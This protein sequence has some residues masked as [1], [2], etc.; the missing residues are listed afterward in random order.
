MIRKQ[1]TQ[2]KEKSIKYMLGCNYH[3][4]ENAHF[5]CFECKSS[6]CSLCIGSHNNHN[7]IDK[8][9]YSMPTEELVNSIVE[10]VYSKISK[11]K[12]EYPQYFNQTTPTSNLLNN[13]ITPLTDY[14][15]SLLH[16]NSLIKSKIAYLENSYNPATQVNKQ[17]KQK[18]DNFINNLNKFKKLCIESLQNQMISSDKSLYI[19]NSNITSE[20]DLILIEEDLFLEIHKTVQQLTKGKSSLL[21]YIDIIYNE[22]IEDIKNLIKSKE[23]IHK[24]LTTIIIQGVS[25]ITNDI[26]NIK[27]LN[28]DKDNKYTASKSLTQFSSQ[29]FQ[30]D[31]NFKAALAHIDKSLII[32]EELD[33]END[34]TKKITYG[35]HKKKKIAD[36][37]SNKDKEQPISKFHQ[38]KSISIKQSA[39]SKQPSKSCTKSFLSARVLPNAA[40]NIK[41][42]GSK[43]KN[44]SFIQSPTELIKS[45]IDSKKIASKIISPLHDN[46]SIPVSTNSSFF[47]S[48]LSVFNLNHISHASQSNQECYKFFKILNNINVNRGKLLK[49]RSNSL[50]ISKQ[51]SSNIKNINEVIKANT[52]LLKR[53]LDKFPA[54][55]AYNTQTKLYENIIIELLDQTKVKKFYEFSIFLNVNNNIYIS[56]G[57]KKNKKLSK[58]FLKYSYIN[59]ELIKLPEMINGKCSHSLIFNDKHQKIYSV[60]GFNSK[61]CEEYS[62][63][64]NKWKE[65]TPLNYIRQVATL[66]FV[67]NKYLIASFGFTS[68]ESYDEIEYFERLNIEDQENMYNIKESKWEM[69]KIDSSGLS[70]YL[71]IFNTGI[72][73]LPE[74]NT[75]LICGGETFQGQETDNVYFLD[76][77]ED[78]MILKPYYS[79]ISTISNT[80]KQYIV[81]LPN[82]TS[83]IDKEFLSIGDGKYAQFEMKRSNIIVFDNNTG[84]FSIENFKI[85]NN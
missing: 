3:Q 72:I 2:I 9:D 11:I 33:E 80:N 26:N 67:N 49:K 44:N 25:S 74:N 78:K 40:N 71:R 23:E 31:E 45:P 53:R 34:A 46:N 76:M 66:F 56:G 29:L 58:L 62:I 17:I 28:F 6:F 22:I 73:P 63:V 24:R 18:L 10:E 81:N 5:Y 30:S 20:E 7:F 68:D 16:L 64:E 37:I 21:D 85:I 50:L 59:N 52:I 75:F 84:N 47:E 1:S 41:M 77:N 27:E 32:N 83:F 8:Y 51:S 60:G 35:K 54:I 57:K 39:F 4:N 14:N 38:I 69:L 79:F 65:L 15:Q 61:T 12:L 13:Q 36:E 55:I 82:K 70:G 19:N 42:I 43:T 48:K